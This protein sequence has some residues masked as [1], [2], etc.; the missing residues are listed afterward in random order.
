MD[1]WLA[2]LLIIVALV[3]G[4]IGGFYLARNYMKDYFKKN[5][6]I[7]ENTLRMMM[8]QMG[9]KPSEKK[10]QQIMKSMRRNMDDNM[11]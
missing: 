11:E 4:L 6:P 7:D 8:M 9:Q 1:L 5:P 10:V 2:I 3:G